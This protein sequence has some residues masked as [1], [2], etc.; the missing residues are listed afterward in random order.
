MLSEAGKQHWYKARE[1]LIKTKSKG[2]MQTYW[3]EV[4]IGSALSAGDKTEEKAVPQVISKPAADEKN[5]VRVVQAPKA[6]VK[7]AQAPKAGGLDDK[8]K[9]LVDWNTDILARLIRQIVARRNASAKKKP[10]QECPAEKLTMFTQQG[11]MVLD[12]VKEIIELPEFDFEAVR[13]QEDPN[14]IELDQAVLDQLRDYVTMVATMYRDNPFHN[15]EHASHVTM[16]VVKL[17]SRIVAPDLKKNCASENEMA[18]TLHDH[19]FGITSDPLTQFSCVLSALIHDVDH[20]G[21]PNAQLVKENTEAAQ[22]YK[23]KS[24]AEQNS[25]DIAWNMLMDSSF[26]DLRKHIC[27]DLTSLTHFR[28]LVVNAVMATDIMDKELKAL[29]SAR[30]EKAFD[31]SAKDSRENINRK[32]TIVIE[33]LIQASDVAHTMQHWH[34]YR[35][36][37]E[38]LYHEMYDAYRRGRAEKDPSEFWY[39]GE[40]GF[41]DFYII[42][43]A[44]KLKNCGVFGVS[45]DEY[46]NYAQ[47]N[48]TEWENKGQEI[49]EKM[50]EKYK[51]QYDNMKPEEK[52]VHEIRLDDIQDMDKQHLRSRMFRSDMSSCCSDDELLKEAE[53]LEEL[54]DFEDESDDDDDDDDSAHNNSNK[55]EELINRAS[56]RLTRQN[57]RDERLV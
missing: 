17:L 47:K 13:D 23:G 1:D 29:R 27:A 24:V 12:E 55:S 35:K 22:V 36:W 14:S 39:K 45:S 10:L 51:T 28:E 42:P 4:K 57:S 53:R 6:E 37:N 54:G 32:A 18:S 49:V 46:L 26:D 20:C 56:V 31:E 52:S 30:W 41:F 11:K 44:K 8:V 50:V 5:A 33:H 34:I 21:V 15:F 2:E 16:S 19:T 43:L 9:R 3:L 7:E 38:R 40:I 48:R 25:V